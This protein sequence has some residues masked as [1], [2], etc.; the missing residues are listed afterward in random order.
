M[1]DLGDDEV[2]LRILHTADW[3]LGKR[4]VSFDDVYRPK[5]TRARLDV[6]DR[7]LSC[8]ESNRVNAVLCAG[9]LFDQPNPEEMWWKGLAEK[10]TKRNWGRFG[11]GGSAAQR[12]KLAATLPPPL[13]LT[14]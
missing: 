5:L 8:A 1:S 6:I 11:S 2:A 10:F 7:I 12:S 13:S 9:D 4:F 3:H 14:P